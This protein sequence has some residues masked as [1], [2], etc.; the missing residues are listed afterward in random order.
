MGKQETNKELHDGSHVGEREG[1]PFMENAS[2]DHDPLEEEATHV[3]ME[4]MLAEQSTSILD[5][6]PPPPRL[7][8]EQGRDR[9]KTYVLNPGET[10]LGRGIDN[11]I[12]LSDVT[13]SRKHLKI[14]NRDGVLTLY[15]LGSGNGT[16]VNGKAVFEVSLNCDDRIRIGETTL[17][18]M[19]GEAQSRF[20]QPKD[21]EIVAAQM[22]TVPPVVYG[23]DSDD[24]AD[25]SKHSVVVPRS[26]L[27]SIMVLGGLVLLSLSVTVVS[28]WL[29][30]RDSRTTAG[31]TSASP[32]SNLLDRA[33]V[34]LREGRWEEA[35]KHISF[36]LLRSPEDRRA[37][38]LMQKVRDAR[39]KSH[40]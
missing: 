21:A 12:I 37:V 28:L 25:K 40:D 14:L 38:M 16:M 19:D 8:V 39:S 11:E 9:G 36:V 4:S 1:A 3:E 2:I 6:I 35:E 22:A 24:V 26:W 31:K 29:V 30:Q 27:I 32:V 10:S 15:D 13:V 7:E 5:G 34:A 20:S 17:C 18:V 23:A 33:E